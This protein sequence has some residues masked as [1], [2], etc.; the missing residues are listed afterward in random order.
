MIPLSTLEETKLF[1]ER[2]FAEKY[3][4]KSAYNYVIC[5][6]ED[7]YP[8]GYINVNIN[9]SY[10][11]GYGLRKEFWHNGIVTEAS[12]VVI[13][14]LRKDGIPYITATHDVSNPRS[15]KVMKYLGMKYQYSYE[16]RWMPK[17]ILVTFRMYQLNLNGSNYNVYKKYW[18]N[19]AVDF[20][21][22][23]V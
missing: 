7:N 14:Q 2:E 8:I 3:I 4:L 10:D 13:E 18:D 23:D 12:K 5:L 6:K 19:S 9:D 21:E 17:D 1:Y 16:E 11:F 22:T 15:G 20:V